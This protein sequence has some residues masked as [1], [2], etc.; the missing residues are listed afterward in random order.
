MVIKASL[1]QALILTKDEEPNIGRVLDK[2]K[3]L[4]SIIILDSDSSDRTVEIVQSFTNTRIYK[5]AFDSHAA[6]W[7]YG[8]SLLN[9]EWVLSL[10]ADYIL[11]NEFAEEVIQKIGSAQ[12]DKSAYCAHFKFL[13]FGK[14]LIKDN[15]TPRPVLFKRLKCKYYDDGHTQRLAIDGPSGEFK[16]F[17]LHDDRKSLSRWLDNQSKYS[18]K[19]CEK[20]I[21]ADDGQLSFTSKLRKN[22]VLAPIFVFFY[23]LIVQRALFAGWRGWHYT[24]ERT[25]VEMLLALRLIEYTKLHYDDASANR[26]RPMPE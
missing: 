11:S 9:G 15:T 22:K 7:N 24:L 18:V 3:W 8:L 14:P 1:L 21:Q 4:E 19:E 23:C 6:Q 2:L 20:L 26:P 10:D 17:I 13:V 12:D 5:R 16:S 25:I